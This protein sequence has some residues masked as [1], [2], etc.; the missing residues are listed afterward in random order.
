MNSVFKWSFHP[1]VWT[2]TFVISTCGG[3]ITVEGRVSQFLKYILRL[4]FIIISF[5]FLVKNQ[6]FQYSDCIT[7]KLKINGITVMGFH[8]K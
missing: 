2:R 3:K 5:I 8:P 6:I 4:D 1:Q 7:S